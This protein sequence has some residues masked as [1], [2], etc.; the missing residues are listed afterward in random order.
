MRQ[1]AFELTL[2]ARNERGGRL[3]PGGG[4]YWE[5]LPHPEAEGAWQRFSGK[6]RDKRHRPGPAGSLENEWLCAR[7][8]KALGLPVAPC[9]MATFGRSKALVVER[10]DR[11]PAPDGHAQNFSLFLERGGQYRLTPLYDVISAYPWLGR[12]PGQIDR[13]KLRMAMAGVVAQGPRLHPPKAVAS[14]ALPGRLFP[15]GSPFPA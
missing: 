14:G 3:R 4:G 10:F 8:I 12:G 2:S 1:R 15:Y 13:E 5:N 9:A 11:R 6:Q 7:L